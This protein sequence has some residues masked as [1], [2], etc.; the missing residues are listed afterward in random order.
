MKGIGMPI[1]HNKMERITLSFTAC[2]YLV[3]VGAGPPRHDGEG[4]SAHDNYL[5]GLRKT[6]LREPSSLD[7]P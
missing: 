2:H 1:N 3:R 5:A 7:R 6:Y 4:N